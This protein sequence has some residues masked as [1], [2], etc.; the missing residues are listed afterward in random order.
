MG[1]P[2]LTALDES[3]GHQL[4]APRAQTL[5]DDPRWAERAYYL[6]HVGPGLTLNAGRQLY[7]HA[8][9]WRVFAGSATPVR[10]D[11]LRREPV[12]APGDDPDAPAVG[13]LAMEV[14]RPMEAVRLVLDAPGF[15]LSYD[16]TFEARFPA[17]AHE[18]TL[19]E[20][21]GEV[22]T[23]TM[24][25]FQSGYFSG[26][27][28]LDGEEHTVE[29]RAGFRD[30]SWG[31]RKHDGSPRRGLVAFVAAEFEDKSLYVLI[32][33]TASGRRAY[34][35]GWLLT[36]E[37]VVDTVAEADH[38]LSFA[39]HWLDGGAVELT[40]ASGRHHR[41]EFETETRYFLSGVG[42]SSDPEAKRP[43]EDRFDLT[44]LDTVARLEGQTDHGSRF[45]LDGEA[46]YG[47]VEIGRGT[48]ARYRPQEPTA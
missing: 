12:F 8:G 17:V 32:H 33:E 7:R 2:Q 16:L 38:D 11:C 19:V 9:I 22:V 41:L 14:I 44:D 24:A 36:E 25:F 4:V 6:L 48:H 15:P 28:L 10:E 21:D 30:R 31:L 3:Y 27:V 40:M 47:Y 20:R 37:G 46:G 5:Y 34:T 26:S 29:R 1:M 39:S 43:G 45:S 42:Y 35:G 18:P 13:S 23:H